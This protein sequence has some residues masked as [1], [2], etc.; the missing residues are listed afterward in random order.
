LRLLG[1]PAVALVAFVVLQA[2]YTG[3]ASLLLSALL[4]GLAASGLNL[5]FQSASGEYACRLLFSHYLLAA[6]AT[7]LCCV[8]AAAAGGWRAA[9]LEASEGLRHV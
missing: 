2:L 8:L 7:L 6:L 4:Y 5:L 3:I 9:H 1:F